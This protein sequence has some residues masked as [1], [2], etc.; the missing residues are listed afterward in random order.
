MRRIHSTLLFLGGALGILLSCLIFAAPAQAAVSV[1]VISATQPD[2]KYAN[3]PAKDFVSDAP[4]VHRLG[5]NADIPVI[6]FIKDAQSDSA[7]LDYISYTR[8]DTNTE[9]IR[10]DPNPDLVVNAS[11]WGIRVRELTPTEVGLTP[12]QTLPLRVD[13]RFR[14]QLIWHTYS[15]HLQVKI[16]SPWPSLPGWYRGDTHFH[17]EFTDNAFEYGG[18]FDFNVEASQAIGMQWTTLTEHS[19]D[20]TAT[21]WDQLVAR[22]LAA[23]N[24]TFRLIPGLEFSVDTNETNESVDDRIHVLGLGLNKWIAGPDIVPSFNV[25]ANQPRTLSAVLTDITDANGV[26]YASH[27]ESDSLPIDVFGFLPPWSNA[28]YTTALSFPVFVG[29]EIFNERPTSVTN[30]NVTTDNMSPFPWTAN[31]NW[32]AEW[33]RGIV[34]YNALVRANIFRNISLLGGSDAHGDAN[35]KVFNANGAFDV[36]ANETASGKVHTVVPLPGGLT[37]TGIMDALRNGRGIVS[38]GPLVIPEIRLG[39]TTLAQVGDRITFQPTAN[40]HV[41]SLSSV[42]FGNLSTLTLHVLSP[43]TEAHQVVPLTG[44]D[45]TFTRTLADLNVA[46]PFAVW[47]EARTT[48]GHRSFSNPIWLN[49][50]MLCGD[51]DGDGK[52][53]IGDAVNIINYIFANGTTPVSGDPNNDGQTDIGDAVYLIN[54]I[55]GGGPAPTC[56][57][58]KRK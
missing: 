31:T 3:T 4:W 41:R 29:L 27:P 50:P 18:N 6:T 53:S 37:Q 5:A 34:R 51:A 49:G 20:V 14:D 32:D 21:E 30:S 45:Q 55:F 17:S 9:I 10:Y 36:A 11:F 57:Q 52:I 33:Q 2:P 44:L 46:P 12:G 13:I 19:Y 22:S 24:A 42:E 54:Y 8:T 56:S 47:V 58:Q 16:A 48:L 23:S 39:S 40:V 25:T 7:L 15:Q 35:Y 28:N 1:E 38:D 43:G 26:A